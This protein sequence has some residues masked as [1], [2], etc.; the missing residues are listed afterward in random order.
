VTPFEFVFGLISIITSLAL[1]KII[2]GVV[3]II[4]HPN[5][6]DSSLV[7]ALWVWVAFALVI[8]NWGA[9]WDARS[10]PDWPALR[11][12]V[13]LTA[14]TSLY[15]FCALVV[16]EVNSGTPLNLTE[17]HQRDSRR[18]IIAHNLF[19]LLSIPV[20]V[21][22]QVVSAS[23]LDFI[24]AIIAFILGTVALFTRGR[25]QF[26]ASL[27]VLVVATTYMLTKIDIL[28]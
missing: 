14:L 10:Y 3:A 4:R 9:L 12:L 7:H 1:T 6:T 5:R 8:G 19:A 18:Y 13:W 11:V 21:T 22:Q 27:L 15:A 16:P 24:P 26:V 25:I 20:L 17:F 28:P 2:T 23:L